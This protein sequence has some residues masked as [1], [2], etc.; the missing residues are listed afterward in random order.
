MKGTQHTPDATPTDAT[1]AVR[2][3]QHGLLN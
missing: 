2:V 1:P 3:G